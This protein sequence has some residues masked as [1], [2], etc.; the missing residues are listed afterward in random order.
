MPESEWVGTPNY[1]SGRKGRTQ[2]AIVDHITAGYYPGCL[3]WM[4]N[5]A[6]QGSAHYLV[7]R[8]GRI[9]QLVREGDT[10]WH[11]GIVNQPNWS[12]YDGTNPNRY[13][14]G[15]EHEG[16]P[17]DGLTEVQYQSSLWLHKDLTQKYGIPIDTDHIVGHYRINSVD[18]YN[19]PGA[20]FPWAKLFA[21]L[22]G[23]S[24]VDNLVIYADGDVGAA[25]L[26]SY[27]LG[28]PM[29]L[30]GF[31]R[32][33]KATNKHYIGVQGTNGNGN[34]YYAG[35]DRVATAKAAL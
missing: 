35:G 24:E 2:L 32:N 26:L 33:V 20:K 3:E 11:A 16:M 30:H 19:C 23:E 31:E 10:A 28:C 4:Q 15:I 29:V 13:T 5:P 1:T 27:K 17:E 9:L 8:D 12:L 18:R 34:Y 25:L 7:L 14:I 6:S 21:D 22:K